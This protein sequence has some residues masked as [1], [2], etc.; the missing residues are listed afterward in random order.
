MKTKHRII[1]SIVLSILLI[2]ILIVA[3]FMLPW[4]ILY[5]AISSSPDPL[6][7]QITY[8]EFPFELVYEINGERVIV[9]DIYVCEYDGLIVS[10]GSG[11]KERTWKG[12]VKSTGDEY[13]VVLAEDNERVVYCFVGDAEF[14]MNDPE[15]PEG[16]A[17]TPHIFDK[18]IISAEI[19]QSDE[20]IEFYDIKIISWQFSK[21]IENTFK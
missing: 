3:Y 9:N 4:I 16:T 12:Y 8:G 19:M 2:S 18:K 11:S 5:W 21:P 17:L 10:E 6:L 14:Y 7:P 15:T 1:L 13:G 20:L